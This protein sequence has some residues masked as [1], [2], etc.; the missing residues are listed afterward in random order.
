MQNTYIARSCFMKLKKNTSK[1]CFTYYEYLQL[2][3]KDVTTSIVLNNNK[4]N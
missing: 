3:D 2:R 1:Y 4:L